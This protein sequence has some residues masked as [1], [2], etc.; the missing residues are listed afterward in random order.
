VLLVVWRL[1]RV[2]SAGTSGEVGCSGSMPRAHICGGAE[3]RAHFGGGRRSSRGV[4]FKKLQQPATEKAKEAEAF[5]CRYTGCNAKYTDATS[6]GAKSKK[7]YGFCSS[8]CREAAKKASKCRVKQKCQHGRPKHK[9]KDCGTGYC[10]HRRRKDMCKD[11]GTGYCQHRLPKHT[12]KD[13]GT[14][15]CEHGRRRG[16]CKDC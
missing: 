8:K 5:T 4:P 12:F 11:C 1:P 2:T 7:N 16:Q 14:G 3:G 6:S 13:C 9:C 15:H 10:Q